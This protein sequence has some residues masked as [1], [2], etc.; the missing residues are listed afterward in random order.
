L[1]IK[2][3]S[4]ADDPKPFMRGINCIQLFYEGARWWIVS[5]YWQQ[6]SP[7]ASNPGKYL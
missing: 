1:A 6:E 4:N 2:N 5:I 3:D 7:G